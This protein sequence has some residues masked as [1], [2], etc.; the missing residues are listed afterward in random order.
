M[1][2]KAFNNFKSKY[3]AFNQARRS[4]K[5][6]NQLSTDYIQVVNR[7]GDNIESRL[8]A[9]LDFMHAHGHLQR[10][11]RAIR[12][13]LGK[14]EANKET[15]FLLHGKAAGAYLGKDPNKNKKPFA[16]PAPK[17]FDTSKPWKKSDGP[18]PLQARGSGCGGNH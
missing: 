6:N 12:E 17:K 18:C 11:V 8:E 10:T 7:L 13:V 15:N 4:P 1:T 2:V 3:R 16:S 14:F 5:S 9:K